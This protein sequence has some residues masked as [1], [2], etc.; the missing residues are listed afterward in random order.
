MRAFV[1]RRV[2]ILS[3]VR[4]YKGTKNSRSLLSV[5]RCRTKETT[6]KRERERKREERR[7]ESEQRAAVK[8]AGGSVESFR[9]A[10]SEL[11]SRCYNAAS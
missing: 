10:N 5:S 8:S 4:D 7:G 2:I 3:C 6:A 1:L 11:I 9:R